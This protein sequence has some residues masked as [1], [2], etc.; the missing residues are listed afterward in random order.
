MNNQTGHIYVKLSNH[1]T[2][3]VRNI[4]NFILLLNNK[5]EDKSILEIVEVSNVTPE[6]E[7]AIKNL[8]TQY[9]APTYFDTR[10]NKSFKVINESFLN[11]NN[12]Q[13]MTI[14][15]NGEAEKEINKNEF[16]YYVSCGI[17]FKSKMA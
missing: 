13:C 15:Y 5:T 9:K 3:T 16:D 11:I 7:K 12:I 2:A 17:W 6:F 10:F 4:E 14:K 1:Y 8:I